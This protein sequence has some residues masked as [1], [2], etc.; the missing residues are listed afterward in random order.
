MS[1]SDLYRE[2]SLNNNNNNSSDVT[3]IGDTSAHEL[4]KFPQLAATVQTKVPTAVYVSIE[5]LWEP[6]TNSRVFNLMFYDDNEE[7]VGGLEL[8]QNEMVWDDQE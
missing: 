7:D 5:A 8:T 6:E 2:V 3:Q 4:R 1:V